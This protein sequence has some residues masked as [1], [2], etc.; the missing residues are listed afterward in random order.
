MQA[1]QYDGLRIK[2]TLKIRAGLFIPLLLANIWWPGVVDC[3]KVSAAG[4]F[5]AEAARAYGSSRQPW[6][7]I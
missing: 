7:L 6:K 5:G 3:A 1:V 2:P 4:C